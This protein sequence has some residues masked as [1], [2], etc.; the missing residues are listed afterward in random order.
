MI[1]MLT[2]GA[3]F[4]IFLLETMLAARAVRIRSEIL[5]HRVD[6]DA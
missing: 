5:Q 6:D 4:G 1:S 2:I 3:G